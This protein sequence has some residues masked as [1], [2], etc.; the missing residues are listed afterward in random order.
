MPI[1][2]SGRA[3][4]IPIVRVSRYLNHIWLMMDK[5]HHKLVVQPNA[6]N[7]PFIRNP[8]AVCS[9]SNVNLSLMLHWNEVTYGLQAY[10]CRGVVSPT[11]DS[12]S[13]DYQIL[14]GL[15][16]IHGMT[17][18]EYLRQNNYDSVETVYARVGRRLGLQTYYKIVGTHNN[19]RLL[20]ETINASRILNDTDF[21]IV[22]PKNFVYT[23]FAPNIAVIHTLDI[24]CERVVLKSDKVLE[25]HTL[26]VPERIGGLN[27]ESIIVDDIL[28]D[29]DTIRTKILRVP[30]HWSVEGL[31]KPLHFVVDDLQLLSGRGVDTPAKWIEP[32]VHIQAK[33]I[34]FETPDRYTSGC[35]DNN[36]R[37]RDMII[38]KK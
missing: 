32:R 23:Y 31:K 12:L 10:Y 5:A 22:I 27:L 35:S 26:R 33:R 8:I 4:F 28:C 21:N 2:A 13:K 37:Y 36:L 19:T 7:V 20:G 29:S 18:D 17:I 9:D 15:A 3:N 34:T 6:V 30:T 24:Q 1:V 38:T 11:L 16:D 25:C 14:C